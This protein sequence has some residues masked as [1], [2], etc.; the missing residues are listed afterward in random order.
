MQEQRHFYGENPVHFVTASTYHRDRLFDSPRFQL[1]FIEI[2][3]QLR[4]DF[5][6]RLLGYVLRPEHFHLLIWSGELADPS[7][8]VGSLKQ[9]TARFMIEN[10]QTCDRAWC[11]RMLEKITL[12]RTVDDE[13]H[14]RV[15]QRRFYDF[16]VWSEE[17]RIEK[18]DYMH[19][20]PLERRLVKG[21][22]DWRWS[23]WR[24]Y[25]LGG[26]AS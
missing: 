15:W 12:P 24:F 25:T 17:K 11:R 7:R 26:P 22:E 13:S 19:G 3:N 1:R 6:F 21:P 5:E 23:S 18:L 14:Y 2:L 16:N 20:N 10:L 9:R 8:I 4:D